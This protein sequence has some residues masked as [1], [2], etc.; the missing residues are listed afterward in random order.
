[1][2]QVLKELAPMQSQTNMPNAGFENLDDAAVHSLGDGRILLQT[3][4]FFTPIVDNPFIFGEIAAVNS[5]SDIYAMGGKPLFALNVTA[6]PSEDL[7]ISTLVDI[8]KGGESIAKKIG[9]QV[10]GGHTIKDKEPKYGW[11]VTGEV[12][13]SGLTANNTAKPGDALILTKPLGSG[14]IT[15]AIK[16][17]IAD[18]N[19]TETVIQTMRTLNDTASQAMGEI[20]VHAATD[21]TGYG[22]LGH[23]LEMCKGS[24]VSSTIEFDKIPFL[25]GVMEL[26]NNGVIPGG[27]KKNLDYVSPYLSFSEIINDAKKYLLADA[28]T[29]G[30]LLISVP[31]DKKNELMDRL[32]SLGTLAYSVIGKITELSEKF[33]YV[34]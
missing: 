8:L 13:E 2:N 31:S 20:G 1:M 18:Q 14:I 33:I 5:L 24:G 9:I 21:I 19:M 27:T 12:S 32:R 7:P 22:L 3:V 23:L 4:D 11:V 17:D 30:G 29:S 10:L 16:K 26:A 6:F 15:T 34:N 25:N 28:Q